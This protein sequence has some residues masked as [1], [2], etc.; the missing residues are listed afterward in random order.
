MPQRSFPHPPEESK[1][2][3]VPATLGDPQEQPMSDAT[4]SKDVAA[5]HP[6]GRRAGVPPDHPSHGMIDEGGKA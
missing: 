6:K 3:S 1:L 2:T 5:E 4:L